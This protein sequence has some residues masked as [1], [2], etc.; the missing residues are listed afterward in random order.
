MYCHSLVPVVWRNVA[1]SGQLTWSYTFHSR[2]CQ[3]PKETMMVITNGM[4]MVTGLL[5]EGFLEISKWEITSE[6]I[7]QTKHF[8]SITFTRLLKKNTAKWLCM[9]YFCDKAGNYTAMGNADGLV[10]S[11]HHLQLYSAGMWS[12]K[13]SLHI[14][15]FY[16]K[17]T[18]RFWNTLIY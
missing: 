11:S 15:W 9:P 17:M 4:G 5:S 3:V 1:I 12:S 16:F 8:L 6:W 2:S 7:Q 13:C 14:Q 18:I 10:K